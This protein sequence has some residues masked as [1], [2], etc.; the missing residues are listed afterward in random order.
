MISH[1][2]VPVHY[3]HPGLCSCLLPLALHGEVGQAAGALLLVHLLA[4]L[5]LLR[6]LPQ[7]G[8]RVLRS[9]LHFHR[10]KALDCCVMI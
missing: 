1:I 5:T 10:G 3:E 4:H 2:S 7:P 8:V 9:S 6:A